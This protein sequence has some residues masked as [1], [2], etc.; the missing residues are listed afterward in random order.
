MTRIL[1]HATELFEA[2]WLI[3]KG[4]DYRCEVSDWNERGFGECLA[5]IYS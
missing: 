5:Q 1:T 2:Q 4:T 3:K